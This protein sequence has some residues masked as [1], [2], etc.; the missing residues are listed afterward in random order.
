MSGASS[1]RTRALGRGAVKEGKGPQTDS[2]RT[3]HGTPPA[4]ASGTSLAGAA[5]ATAGAAKAAAAGATAAAG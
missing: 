4:S 1:T 5:R 3:D 2:R